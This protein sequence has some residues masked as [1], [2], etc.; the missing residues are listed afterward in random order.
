MY[1]INIYYNRAKVVVFDLKE[2]VSFILTEN[3]DRSVF[4]QISVSA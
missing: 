2:D 4:G 3:W 1:I